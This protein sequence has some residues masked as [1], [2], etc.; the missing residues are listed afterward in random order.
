MGG[1]SVP[2]LLCR[3]AA[4]GPNSIGTEVPPTKA[5]ASPSH[6]STRQSLPQKHPPVPPQKHPV[7]SRPVFITRRPLRRLAPGAAMR[8]SSRRS[9]APCCVP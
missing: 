2:M 7:E 4:S 3:I 5:P 9:A 8:P 6:K 1:T